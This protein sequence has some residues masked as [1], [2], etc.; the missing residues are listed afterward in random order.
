MGNVVRLRPYG[1]PERPAP[2]IMQITLVDVTT[3]TS[4]THEINRQAL[5][6][7]AAKN[8]RALQ[9]RRAAKR[10]MARRLNDELEG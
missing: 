9:R 7:L 4:H 6:D 10:R 5:W 8:L 2:G 3:G 1:L